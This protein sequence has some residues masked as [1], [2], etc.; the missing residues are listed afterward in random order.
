MKQ[1][2]VY[3]ELLRIIASFLVIYNHLPAIVLINTTRGTLQDIHLI[4]RCI[5][6]VS[7]PVF[8]MISG[9]VLL[10]KEE[11][12]KK[13]FSKR[14]SRMFITMF[15]FEL[16]MYL[17]TIFRSLVKHL[18]IY[19]QPVLTFIK[20]FLHGD[21]D[22]TDAYWYLY[23]YLAFLFTLPLLQRI[24]AKYD[25]KDFKFWL[26]LHF[27]FFTLLPGINVF[28]IKWGIGE[29][30]ICG[31][32]D[33]PFAVD[34]IYFYPF[35]G[36]YLDK[37]DLDK[38][39]KKHVIGM[40]SIMVITLGLCLLSFHNGVDF[41][42]MFDYIISLDLFIMI[43]YLTEKVLPRLSNWDKLSKRICFIGSLTFGI[44]LLH[45]FVNYGLAGKWHQL[46]EPLIGTFLTSTTWVIVCMIIAGTI[47]Y[48][49]KKYTIFKKLL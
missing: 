2:K 35:M 42:Q 13:V 12:I 18:P 29:L 41:S 11:S 36:F 43:R 26:F 8:L 9:T 39:T 32:F 4:I 15:I 3:L 40:I 45:I 24:A 27:F 30:D 37:L 48:F 47:T 16:G 46:F 22:S 14:V 33:I 23:M 49:L 44:Y 1:K 5:V 20:G 6:M 21:L 28:L 38:F 17:L 34:Q 7:V 10:G 31:T 19:E 25:E